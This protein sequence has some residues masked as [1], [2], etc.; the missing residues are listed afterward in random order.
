MELVDQSR[1]GAQRV[2]QQGGIGGVMDVGFHHRG[3]D[4]QLLAVFQAELDRTLD[5][6]LVDGL[7]GGRGEPV[8]GAVEGV[9]LGYAMAVEV[10]KAAPGIAIV[11]AF[12]QLAIVPVFD[13]HEDERAQGLRGGDAAAS[14]VGVLQSARQILAH[15][16]DQRG[17]VVQESDDTLQERVEVDAL[18]S[19]F[20]I[21]E[22]E[23]GFGDTG[24]AFFSGRKSCWFNSQMRSK[25]AFSFR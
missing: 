6:G 22:A 4:A 12:A 7:H 8:E 23:L 25:V 17:M 15:L 11:D 10:G 9:V 2:P 3:V 14:G 20:E 16:L 18:V 19:Q 13:A 24:H 1:D 5:Y 21:G